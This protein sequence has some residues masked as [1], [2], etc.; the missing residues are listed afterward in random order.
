MK[1]NNSS[2]FN[3][4]LAL[5]HCRLREVTSYSNS[6]WEVAGKDNGAVPVSLIRRET[7][8]STQLAE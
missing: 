1:S 8:R 6:P 3:L 5:Y 7:I 2:A 4:Q